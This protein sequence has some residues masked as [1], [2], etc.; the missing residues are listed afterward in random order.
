MPNDVRSLSLKRK[1]KDNET[2]LK[3][4]PQTCNSLGCI[5]FILFSKT[6]EKD[7]T[8]EVYKNLKNF[9]VGKQTSPS[10]ELSIGCRKETYFLYQYEK[11][12]CMLH[13]TIK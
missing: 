4:S 2:N 8:T 5:I 11:L 12:Q 10:S 13:S 3:L 7:T 6:N 1:T 9:V